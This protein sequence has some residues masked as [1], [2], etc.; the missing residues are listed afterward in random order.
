MQSFSQRFSRFTCVSWLSLRG[1][2]RHF[3]DC[4]DR[5][6][7]GGHSSWLPTNNIK[8]TEGAMLSFKKHYSKCN[9]KA[10][11][12][13]NCCIT[14]N[15]LLGSLNTLLRLLGQW[16]CRVDIQ[17]DAQSTSNVTGRH[18]RPKQKLQTGYRAPSLQ[19]TSYLCVG[20]L[21]CA[22]SIRHCRVRYCALSVRCA[23]YAHNNLCIRCFDI[24]LA[25]RL[26]L[27]QISFLSHPPLLS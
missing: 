17:C 2:Q 20:L 1:L 19:H 18:Q 21:C 12:Y 4:L 9:A 24:I 26:P 25:P 15:Y 3:H 13:I 5:V 16:L 11:N 14:Y 8:S 7:H 10:I 27:C 6:L 22:S 23:H